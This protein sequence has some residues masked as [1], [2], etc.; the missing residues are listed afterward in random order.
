VA[1]QD[2][3][4][5]DLL[6]KLK[7]T[8]LYDSA[9]VVVTADHGV[10]FKPGGHRRTITRENFEDILPVP[11]F[12]KLP[13]QREGAV[14]DRNVQTIDILPTMANLLGVQMP[15]AVDGVPLFDAASP[16]PAAKTLVDRSFKEWTFNPTIDEKYETTR[17]KVALFG[18][19]NLQERLFKIGPYASVIGS[20]VDRLNVVG[21]L[22]ATAQLNGDQ[23]LQNH[24]PAS[25]YVPAQLTGRITLQADT[26]Q[27]LDVAVALNGVVHATARTY[28]DSA[29]EQRLSALV[30]A[31]AFV[32]GANE[33]A[34]YSLSGPADRPEA[35]VVELRSLRSFSLRGRGDDTT[36]A[37]SS[38]E[39][40]RLVSGAVDGRLEEA[41]VCGPYATMTGWSADAEGAQVVDAVVMF[42]GDKLVWAG[43]PTLRRPDVVKEYKQ[44]ALL[45]SG[46]K[47][48]LPLD[49]LGE[50]DGKGL[51][52][53]ALSKRGVASE[54]K[55]PGTLVQR[56]EGGRACH[57]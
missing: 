15:A 38:G 54:L 4:L 13:G 18:S 23:D 11:L 14:S 3:L 28:L 8:G 22:G 52:V 39:S 48:F 32:A 47:A 40:F 36:I 29:R 33:V 17:Q 55:R 6:T 1:Y 51:R 41:E 25:L 45:L 43:P 42:V 2:T 49:A 30:P 56:G 27:T 9:L 7:E 37:S 24:D 53:F 31:D 44:E 21:S 26:D 20:P 12:I 35:Q 50:E 16:E 19:G 34:L 57:L 46:F 10:S 5:G